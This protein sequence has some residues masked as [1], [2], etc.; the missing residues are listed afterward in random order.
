MEKVLNNVFVRL[1]K[2]GVP[3]VRI[4]AKYVIIASIIL[5]TTVDGLVTVLEV[6]IIDIFIGS[7]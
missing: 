4:I 1:V 2:I 7:L 3:L 5:T 6:E